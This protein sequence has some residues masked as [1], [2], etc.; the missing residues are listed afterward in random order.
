METRSSAQGNCGAKSLAG[1]VVDSSLSSLSS[2]SHVG[3]EGGPGR[4]R[5]RGSRGQG[6]FHPPYHI[7][8]YHMVLALKGLRTTRELK[9][10]TLV[11]AT[12]TNM[13]SLHSVVAF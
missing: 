12:G 8:H 13:A 2:T 11:R 1:N 10:Q 6:T 3:Q 7:L 9:N 5:G 4:G